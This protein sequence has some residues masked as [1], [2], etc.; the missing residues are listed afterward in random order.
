M[1]TAPQERQ[2]MVKVNVRRAP[3]TRRLEHLNYAVH[4]AVFDM[5]DVAEREILMRVTDRR[6]VE[7]RWLLAWGLRHILGMTVSGVA[8]RFGQDHTTIRHSIKQAWKHL[9]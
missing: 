7:A 6:I 1:M 4:Q 9:P 5:T 3:S 2:E 8:R